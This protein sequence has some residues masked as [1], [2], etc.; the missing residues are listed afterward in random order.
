MGFAPKQDLE[1]APVYLYLDFAGRHKY[2]PVGF[3]PA[4]MPPRP[5][6]SRQRYTDA[7]WALGGKTHPNMNNVNGCKLS[8]IL[9]FLL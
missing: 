6:K 7:Y 8:Q 4:S 1:N 3:A 5:A 2:I 9:V